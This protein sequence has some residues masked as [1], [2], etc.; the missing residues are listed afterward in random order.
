MSIFSIAYPSNWPTEHWW[1]RLSLTALAPETGLLWVLGEAQTFHI[2]VFTGK[3]GFLLLSC[4]W[5][6]SPSCPFTGQKVS[7]CHCRPLA[8]SWG[9]RPCCL[10]GHCLALSSATS[11][12]GDLLT[13]PQLL[14]PQQHPITVS[15]PGHLALIPTLPRS[16]DPACVPTIMTLI[17]AQVVGGTPSSP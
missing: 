7:S 15:C 11:W 9:Q 17:R 16:V 3:H 6:V 2:A 1:L 10:L 14:D 8:L 4:V 12:L 13:L 5:I